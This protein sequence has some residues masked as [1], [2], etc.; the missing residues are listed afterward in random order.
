MSS[1]SSSN[2]ASVRKYVKTL[3]RAF[4]L[5]IHPD[6]FRQ[7]SHTIRKEQGSLVQAIE[8]WLSSPAVLAY[9]NDNRG[10]PSFT[11]ISTTSTHSHSKYPFHLERSDGTLSRHFL[12]LN[13]PVDNVLLGMAT[14]LSELGVHLPPFPQNRTCAEGRKAINNNNDKYDFSSR[15]STSTTRTTSTE[16]I[17]E[18]MFRFVWSSSHH[19]HHPN[20]KASPCTGV[21]EQFDIISQR[22]KHLQSFVQHGLDYQDINL[23]KQQRLAAI[24]SA[25]VTRRAFQF[26]AVDGTGIGWSSASLTQCFH[27]LTQLWQ[28]HRHRFHVTSFFPLRLELSKDERRTKQLCQYG[29]KL[30]LNPLDT[31]IQWVNTLM[32]VTPQT[33]KD[34][35]SIQEKLVQYLKA[36]QN[37]TLFGGGGI[38][39]MKRGHSCTSEEYHICLQRLAQQVAKSTTST[40]LSTTK[41]YSS[42]NDLQSIRTS[43]GISPSLLLLLQ[44]QPQYIQVI[45]ETT[46]SLRLRGSVTR[47]GHIRVSSTMEPNEIISTIVQL[48][49]S[50]HKV[51]QVESQKQ[52][53][54]E[55]L[56]KHLIYHWNLET[57]RIT[58]PLVSTTQALE[59]VQRLY[60]EATT[61]SDGTYNNSN[62]TSTNAF[63]NSTERANIDWR[64]RLQGQS[65]G[66]SCSGQFCHIAD[67]GCIV[68]P[69]DF[70]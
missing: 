41:Q 12:T 46:D 2:H 17:Y 59:C 53:D 15:A 38:I 67:D 7:H 4:L 25:L 36:I 13:A 18:H 29:G 58:S 54:Y 57:I 9:Y 1:S 14:S 48:A 49:E 39:R 27:S 33:L 21:D 70:R 8:E 55:E 63:G 50:A 40:T 51:M 24:A 56:V 45:V 32:L 22:G 30:Y 34:M 66:I 47:E 35:R 26:Q 31:P 3:R 23:R 28:D 65:I 60:K 20:M 52:A 43:N 69:W 44:P 16:A 37:S 19:H 5:R 62:N 11:G 68:I 64:Q 6:R 61:T 10:R 42:N